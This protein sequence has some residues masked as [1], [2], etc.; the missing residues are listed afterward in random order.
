LL[1]LPTTIAV[2]EEGDSGQGN[3]VIKHW[4]GVKHE[5]KEATMKSK[6]RTM[7]MDMQDEALR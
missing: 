6:K 4:D 2:E 1:R 3:G 7:K 5:R